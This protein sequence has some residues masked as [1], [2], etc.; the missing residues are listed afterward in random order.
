[1]VIQRGGVEN[2]LSRTKLCYSGA[3]SRTVTASPVFRAIF[4]MTSFNAKRP[5]NK[6]DVTAFSARYPPVGY[7]YGYLS[8][9]MVSGTWISWVDIW[10]ITKYLQVRYPRYPLVDTWVN[11]SD[12][13]W[14]PPADTWN[15]LFNPQQD[16]LNSLQTPIEFLNTTQNSLSDSSERQRN[17]ERCQTLTSA[18]VFTYGIPVGLTYECKMGKMRTQQLLECQAIMTSSGTTEKAE[19]KT[20]D[21]SILIAVLAEGCEN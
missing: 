12:I 11:S 8:Y 13:G 6:S 7:P 10:N 14:Y 5:C 9:Q 15:I 21:S 19:E 4:K 2:I 1:M 3:G 18:K 16:I 20:W 17:F